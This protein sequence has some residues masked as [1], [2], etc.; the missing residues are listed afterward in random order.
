MY[1]EYGWVASL[2]GKQ[3]CLI[4]VLSSA[5]ITDNN[6]VFSESDLVTPWL[7]DGQVI[8]NLLR[9]RHRDV[10]FYMA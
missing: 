1:S 9:D 6:Y 8:V 5:V 2:V 4:F 3:L 10:V 7:W